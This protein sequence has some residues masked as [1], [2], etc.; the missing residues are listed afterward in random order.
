M[1]P[2]RLG[3]VSANGQLTVAGMDDALIARRPPFVPDRIE[4]GRR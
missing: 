4:E 1:T 3:A 2:P